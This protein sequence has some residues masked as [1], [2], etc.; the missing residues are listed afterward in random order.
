[1]AQL[2]AFLI[3]RRSVDLA[4][5]SSAHFVNPCTIM[6]EQDDR[7]QSRGQL[8]W[9]DMASDEEDQYWSVDNRRGHRRNVFPP[10]PRR[11]NDVYAERQGRCS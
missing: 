3:V 11:E 6:N 7:Q 1:M 10:A 8:R 2:F 4:D 5:M 9:A